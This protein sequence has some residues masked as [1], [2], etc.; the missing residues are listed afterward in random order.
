MARWPSFL[1][2]KRKMPREK[3][4]LDRTMGESLDLMLLIVWNFYIGSTCEEGHSARSIMRVIL[5]IRY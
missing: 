2:K 4:W 3:G 5:G 1:S